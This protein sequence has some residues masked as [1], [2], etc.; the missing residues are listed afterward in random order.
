MPSAS[1]YTP[2]LF[3]PQTT[4]YILSFQFSSW[5]PRFASKSIKSTVIRP[6]PEGEKEEFREWLEMDG[7][8]VPEGADDVC[9]SLSLIQIFVRRK[10]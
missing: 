10:G 4:T 5:Y 8:V 6:L 7:V 1:T 2:T 9:V 3:P